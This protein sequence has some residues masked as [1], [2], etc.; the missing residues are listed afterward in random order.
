MKTAKYSV[1]AVEQPN[2]PT[3]FFVAIQKIKVKNRQPFPQAIA[4]F[5]KT[6]FE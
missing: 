2:T 6:T 3:A 1:F 5:L 4:R